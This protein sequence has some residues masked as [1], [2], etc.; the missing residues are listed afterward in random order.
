MSRETQS[1]RRELGLGKIKIPRS[2]DHEQNWQPYPA[3]VYSAM[4]NDY[5]YIQ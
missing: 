1:F 4:N 3:D 2:A 5:T